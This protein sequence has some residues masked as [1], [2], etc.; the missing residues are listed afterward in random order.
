LMVK[1]AVAPEEPGTEAGTGSVYDPTGL[2]T[3]A[4]YALPRFVALTVPDQGRKSLM[5]KGAVAA[6]LHTCREPQGS[7]FRV[8]GSGFR[9]QG[10]GFRVQG[11]GFRVQGS[12]FRVQGPGFR[13]QGSGFRVQGSGLRVQ[14]L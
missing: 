9:V 3:V 12:G 10:S 1:G 13:V 4:P 6:T 5:V 8:Q 14:G 11:S 2:P 7:G